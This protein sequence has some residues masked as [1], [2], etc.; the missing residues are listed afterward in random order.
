MSTYSDNGLKNGDASNGLNSWN[1]LYTDVVTTYVGEKVF[2]V[3]PNGHL[4]QNII[5]NAQ[6]SAIAIKGVFLP[7][8]AIS[9]TNV[10]QYIKVT[11]KYSDNSSD[12]IVI[13]CVGG[14][15]D[16]L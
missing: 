14:D 4:I 5:N 9:K 2:K 16:G 15:K 12:V 3:Q 1:S 8:S 6:P 10:K 7:D 11:L 13:P